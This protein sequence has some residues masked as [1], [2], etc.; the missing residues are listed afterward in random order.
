[1]E[2][3]RVALDRRVVKIKKQSRFASLSAPFLKKQKMLGLGCGWVDN[4]PRWTIISQNCIYIA[5]VL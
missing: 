4:G 2:A 1:L 5:I 3:I